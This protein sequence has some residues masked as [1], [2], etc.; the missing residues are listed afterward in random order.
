MEDSRQNIS[1]KPSAFSSI[2]KARRTIVYMIIVS[3]TSCISP[4]KMD[5]WIGEQYG[6]TAVSNKP[7]ADYFTL[8]SPLLTADNKTSSSTKSTRKFLPLI[9]YWQVDYRIS[10]TLNPKVPMNLFVSAFTSYAS[11]KSLKQK[12]NGQKLE[13]SINKMP[14]AFSFND[15]FR[16]INLVLAQI[17]WEKI[18]ILPEN[19]DLMITYKLSKD[20]VETKS[21]VINIADPNKIKKKTY[22]KKMKTATLEYLT[23]YNENIKSMARSA[24]DQM[25]AEL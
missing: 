19:T 11:S 9:F 6:E 14:T 16:D 2:V 22:F 13:M 3:A 10:S 20:N 17:H 1:L 24:V 25:L 23:Q 12:L 21:G 18:Y 8:T 7:K 15:D 5:Q 4:K